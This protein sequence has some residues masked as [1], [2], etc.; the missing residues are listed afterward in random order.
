[1]VCGNATAVCGWAE[2]FDG[3]LIGSAYLMYNTAWSL[4]AVILLF[5]A[6]EFMLYLKTENVTLTWTTGVI[7][8]SIFWS[9]AYIKPAAHMILAVIM[10]VELGGLFYLLVIKK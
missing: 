6:F 9:T 10:A 5:L 3:N 4:W 8:T 2:L 7:F 1:M